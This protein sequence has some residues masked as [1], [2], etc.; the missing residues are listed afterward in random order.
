MPPS[1]GHANRTFGRV[2]P[3]DMA[4]WALDS[5][6]L[7]SVTVR[8]L[9]SCPAARR[10]GELAGPAVDCAVAVDI[11][12]V[13]QPGAGIGV[14]RIVRASKATVSGTLPS[15]GAAPM[16]AVGG[17]PRVHTAGA[18]VGHRGCL[19]RNP[20]PILLHTGRRLGRP[21]YRLD[22]EIRSWKRGD[23]FAEGC[24]LRQSGPRAASCAPI[25]TMKLPS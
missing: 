1:S 25:H 4:D 13:R 20:F 12:R 22:A 11:P 2:L 7:S 16:R 23:R 21:S 8:G 15:V 9:H 19:P 10:V 6:P 17:R 5:S 24:P 14:V 3:A 18:P